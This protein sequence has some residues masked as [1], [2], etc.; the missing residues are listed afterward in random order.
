MTEQDPDLMTAAEITA[1]WA[2][3]LAKREENPD[4]HRAT[5]EARK[6]L[7]AEETSFGQYQALSAY[8]DT[9][10]FEL[11]RFVNDAE[12]DAAYRD[13]FGQAFPDSGPEDLQRALDAHMQAMAKA[14]DIEL[15]NALGGMSL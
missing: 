5:Y 14:Y 8:L 6:H 13:T 3:N 2:E 4:F 11:P 7:Y 1:G 15:D 9:S 12:R 10:D